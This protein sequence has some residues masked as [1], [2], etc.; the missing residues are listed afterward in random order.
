ML[1]AV[2]GIDGSGKSTLID[3][4]VPM[5]S[6][7]GLATARF[8]G[9]EA[10]GR[11]LGA[12][13]PLATGP[14]RQRVEAFIAEYLGW[15]LITNSRAALGER[16]GA[17]VVVADRF[18]LD[19]WA[20]QLVFGIGLDELRWVGVLAPKADLTVMVDVPSELAWHRVAAREGGPGWQSRAFLQQATV[21]FS[22]C[23]SEAPGGPV[24]R[25][26]GTRTEDA[27]ADQLCRVIQEAR[28]DSQHDAFD[29]R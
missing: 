28:S 18:V 12:L 14:D 25:L 23:V 2:S 19:H 5:L 22:A 27:L 4:V 13:R 24:L 17:D 11:F 21:A 3:H 26:D 7:V 8:R 1:V 20:N 6:K 10:E 15:K 16:Q 29:V 9:L